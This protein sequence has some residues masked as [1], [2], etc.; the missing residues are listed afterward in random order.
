[1][2]LRDRPYRHDGGRAAAG[3][4]PR[5]LRVASSPRSPLPWWYGCLPGRQPP[6]LERP[7]ALPGRAPSVD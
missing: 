1:M 2:R 6:T 5:A 7:S 4:L 3:P